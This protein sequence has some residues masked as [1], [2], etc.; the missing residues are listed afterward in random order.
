MQ[1]RD[2]QQQCD[3]QVCDAWDDGAQNVMLCM[4][5]GG[6][7]TVLFCHRVQQAQCHS[8]I[9]VHRQ[10]LI[11]QTA[12]TLNDNGI[13]HSIKAPREVVRQVVRAQCKLHGRSYY[14][15]NAIVK[16][17]SV[18]STSE[19]KSD[20]KVEL[21][22]MDEGHHVLVANKWGKRLARYPAAKGLFV[23][24]HA[25]R[26]DGL[27][28][29]RVGGAGL[30]DALVIGPYGRELIS[31]GFLTDYRP[32]CPPSDVDVS[33]VEISAATG[34]YNQVQLRD[35]VHKS[36]QLVG[37]VIRHYCEV[38]GGKLGITFAVDIIEATKLQDAYRAAGVPAEIITAKTPTTHRVNLMERFRARQILQLVSVDVLGEGVDVPAIEVVSFARHTA[39]WQLYCQQFGR[40]LRVLVDEQ[41][42]KRWGEYSDADRR[43][44]IA[45]STKPKA[46]ILDH[47]G[48]IARHKVLRG[49]PDSKQTYDLRTVSR[50][51]LRKSADDAIP[52]RTCLGL[53]PPPCLYPYEAILS[54]CPLCGTPK[55]LPRSRG[56]IEEVEG[57]LIEL[58]PLALDASYREIA[59]I[60]GACPVRGIDAAGYGARKAWNAR[61]EAQ[62]P[63]RDMIALWAGH[64]KHIGR[65][66]AETY[67]LFWYK[68][69]VDVAT[70]MTL[71]TNDAY[72]LYARLIDDL[73]EV[74]RA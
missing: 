14:A 12:L 45:A 41:Y 48:N 10:E 65:D 31:R 70:A 6:G 27:G 66:E 39:S 53:G 42:A 54:A 69:N 17:E 56:N 3:R 29:G 61:Q 21:V 22:V 5:T 30:V 4:P 52:T 26:A 8:R 13:Y 74:R 37:S 58:D 62:R 11:A 38:A 72:R 40:A 19:D 35:E 16:V 64:Q 59:R 9:V 60:D 32:M 1:L 51:A 50:A 36:K 24:A 55:P 47:V 46:I 20:V 33:E 23:T 28:L 57:N 49:L 73:R 44:I 67:R 68:Y 71:G 43:A 34:D 15:P 25:C 7:K 2:F 18:D 63:L